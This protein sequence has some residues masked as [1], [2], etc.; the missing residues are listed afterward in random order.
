[1]K[2]RLKDIPVPLGQVLSA[3][4]YPS[5]RLSQLFDVEIVFRVVGVHPMNLGQCYPQ[6]WVLQDRTDQ[7][8]QEFL[9]G[10]GQPIGGAR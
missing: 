4:R 6:M 3:R 10:L 1:M 9:D 2:P 5:S 7:E 8:S